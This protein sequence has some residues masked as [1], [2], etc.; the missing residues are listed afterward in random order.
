MTYTSKKKVQH[1]Y[2]LY[3]FQDVYVGIVLYPWCFGVVGYGATYFVRRV[4][5]A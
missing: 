5:K 2:H 1:V 3:T 4:T